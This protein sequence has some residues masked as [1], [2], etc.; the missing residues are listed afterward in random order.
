M[1][2]GGGW[3]VGDLEK[4]R[5]DRQDVNDFIMRNGVLVKMSESVYDS[6]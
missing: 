6:V 1:G 5:V 3:E 4:K 2:G